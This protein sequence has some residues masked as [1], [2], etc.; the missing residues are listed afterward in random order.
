MHTLSGGLEHERAGLVSPTYRLRPQGAY[1]LHTAELESWA[2]LLVYPGGEAQRARAVRR[3][4][5]RR[6]GRVNSTRTVAEL[7][8]SRSARVAG[9]RRALAVVD[10][11]SRRN[12]SSDR[13]S[14][15]AYK[16]GGRSGRDRK[17]QG[18]RVT[19][20]PISHQNDQRPFRGSSAGERTQRL[21]LSKE[22]LCAK[23]PSWWPERRTASTS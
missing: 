20:Q 9:P 23:A 5:G 3:R 6:R 12:R 10:P 18:R 16:E 21:P 11:R 1:D 2:Q 15:A 13:R 14:R 8:A 22:G 19:A 17:L 4:E 7:V